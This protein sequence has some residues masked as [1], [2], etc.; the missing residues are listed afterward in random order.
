MHTFILLKK[1][2]SVYFT[3]LLLINL[4][5]L[6]RLLCVIVWMSTPDIHT[7]LRTNLTGYTG[8]PV[9]TDSSFESQRGALFFIV[10]CCKLFNVSFF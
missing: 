10:F 8:C 4:Y 7:S 3:Q 2:Y 6:Q 9:Q 1:K 5:Y